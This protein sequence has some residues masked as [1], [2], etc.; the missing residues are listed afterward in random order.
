VALLFTLS[1]CFIYSA[2]FRT[3]DDFTSRQLAWALVALVFFFATVQLGYRF[4]LGISYA[5]YLFALLCLVWV[6]VAGAIHL[7]AQRWIELGPISIQPSEFAK[8]AAILALAN[9]LGSHPRWE[10]EGRAMLVTAL[11]VGLPFL[12]VMKQ[13]DL[14]SAALFLPLGVL[15][16][17]LWGLRYRYLIAALLTG[18]LACP[19]LWTVLKEY[20]RKRILVFLNPNLDPLGAGYTAIQ[21]KIAVG[22]GGLFGKGWLHGTQSQLDFIPEH[23]TDFIFSVIAEETG[24]VGC[25][26]LLSLFGALF[27]H[28]FQV[29]ERTTDTKARLIGAGILSVLFFQMLV[30]IGMTF[31]LFPITGITLPWV[32]YGGSSLVMNA[33][34]LGLLTSIYRERSIF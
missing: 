25:L 27:F 10:G 31:G 14:G 24:F 3:F 29:V 7:G 28:I 15:V 21:S 22:S 19:L 2:T 5:F 32:S 6:D 8:L 16:L 4:F 18:L 17:F 12:L 23:H 26:V 33:I 34:G 1:V 13:P 9:F 30:N 11:L 20:Q